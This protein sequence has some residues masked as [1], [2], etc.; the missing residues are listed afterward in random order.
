MENSCRCD[1][2]NVDVHRASMQKRLRS[3]K[4]LENISQNDTIIPERLFKEEQ[5]PIKNKIKKV[6]NPKT[7]KQIARENI[8][9]NDKD[10]DKELAEKM[11][12]PYYFIDGNLKNGS[13]IFLEGHNINHANSVLTITPI[14][15][16]FGIETRYINK[17]LKEMATIYARLINEY[18]F[19]CHIL[20]SGSFYKVNEE[21]QRSD[22][23]K[24]FI[25]LNIN[26]I[27][28]ETDFKSLDVKSQIEH[29][30]Q[31]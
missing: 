21:D 14:Y 6:Y 16:D 11:I 8:E 15:S 31:T 22:E 5:T 12:D 29:Q 25:N 1:N 4:R 2:C 18:K 9:M 23:I 10:L 27:L 24:F 26:R 20:F 7:L 19:K 17:I 30:I 28:T 13:K 3:K